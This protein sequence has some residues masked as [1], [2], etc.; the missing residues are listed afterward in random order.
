MKFRGGKKAVL[1][2][3]RGRAAAFCKRTIGGKMR[4]KLASSSSSSPDDEVDVGETRASARC[5]MR[6]LNA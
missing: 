3:W 1:K 2:N 5:T 4:I 6:S